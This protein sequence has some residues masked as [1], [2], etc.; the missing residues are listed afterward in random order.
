MEYSIIWICYIIIKNKEELFCSQAL[1][2]AYEIYKQFIQRNSLHRNYYYRLPTSIESKQ[3][4]ILCEKIAIFK[5]NLVDTWNCIFLT[6][7][8][9]AGVDP[10]NDI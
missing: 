3:R 6:Y 8:T 4:V 7:F 2:I 10:K 1:I 9:L 5:K